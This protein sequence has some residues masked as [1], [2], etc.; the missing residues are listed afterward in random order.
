MH[1]SLKDEAQKL[2]I[3]VDGK[4]SD[5]NAVNLASSI[6]QEEGRLRCIRILVD[7]IKNLMHEDYAPSMEVRH[8]KKEIDSITSSGGF[9]GACPKP[10]IS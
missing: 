7:I 3:V 2:L 8:R 4:V 1:D 9:E 6:K 10:K 5:N